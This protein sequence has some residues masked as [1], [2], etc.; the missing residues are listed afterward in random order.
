MSLRPFILP[1]LYTS[2]TRSR[3]RYLGRPIRTHGLRTFQ[4]NCVT[5]SSLS[6]SLKSPF[7]YSDF[8]VPHRLIFVVTTTFTSNLHTD[9]CLC[10]HRQCWYLLS[11]KSPFSRQ[12][13]VRRPPSVSFTVVVPPV[14][15]SRTSYLP[16]RFLVDIPLCR[17]SRSRWFLLHH[18]S[19][20]VIL[21]VQRSP[22]VNSTWKT[23]GP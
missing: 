14:P 21:L 4:L 18:P 11:S 3:S 2:S 19:V 17:S 16:T 1:N 15:S 8:K 6:S 22:F 23:C 5:P 12:N 13:R 20:L 10:T 7:D 9:L